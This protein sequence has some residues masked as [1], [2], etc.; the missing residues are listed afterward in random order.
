MA[1]IE[2]LSRAS[3][4]YITL[5]EF[6]DR[7]L[8]TLQTPHISSSI[9]KPQVS[10]MSQMQ[11]TKNEFLHFYDTI[12]RFWKDMIIQPEDAKEVG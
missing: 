8:V 5:S 11:M 6:E 4:E 3:S 2:I 10:I 9:T 12:D 7:V 1:H